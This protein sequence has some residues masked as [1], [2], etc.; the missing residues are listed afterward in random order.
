MPR[1][2]GAFYYGGTMGIFNDS[3]KSVRSSVNS[4]G[5][6]RKGKGG[7]KKKTPGAHILRGNQPKL[8]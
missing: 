3:I 8:R 1:S 4:M 5:G 6:K 7:G 2:G